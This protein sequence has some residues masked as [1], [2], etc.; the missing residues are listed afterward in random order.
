M[1]SFGFKRSCPRW[2]H[3]APPT[4]SAPIEV[5]RRSEIDGA[6]FRKRWGTLTAF[7]KKCPTSRRNRA[8]L[9]L[10]SLPHFNRNQCPTSPGIRRGEAWVTKSF[11]KLLASIL[12]NEIAKPA[13]RRV[14]CAFRPLLDSAALAP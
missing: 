12:A 6:P 4:P 9:R 5:G 7:I 11:F 8:P 13:R 3:P 10:E 14:G 1:V 2:D